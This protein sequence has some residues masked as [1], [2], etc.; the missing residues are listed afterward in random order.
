MNPTCNNRSLVEKSMNELSKRLN[1]RVM[2]REMRE[3]IDNSYTTSL[4]DLMFKHE[5]NS[6][7]LPGSIH[8]NQVVKIWKS[9]NPYELSEISGDSEYRWLTNDNT[10]KEIVIENDEGAYV[11][12]ATSRL[13]DKMKDYIVN[14][15]GS[16]LVPVDVWNKQFKT[17]VASELVLGGAKNNYIVFVM[18]LCMVIV[19]AC[20]IVSNY[21]DMNIDSK[22]VSQIME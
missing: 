5:S 3:R 11:K 6:S 8:P 18:L 14:S 9:Y 13:N 1:E 17:V 4:I 2:Q 15:D 20:I 19:I 21:H 12:T 22:H 10:R 16:V 7:S